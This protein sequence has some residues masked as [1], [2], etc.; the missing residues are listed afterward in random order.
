MSRR[1]FHPAGIFQP[2]SPERRLAAGFSQSARPQPATNR[3]SC[4]FACCALREISRLGL[5]RIFLSLLLAALVVAVEA[6][7]RVYRIMPLGD[8]I[9]EGGRTFSNYRYPLWEKLFAAGYLVEFVGSRT[10]ESRVGPL[11]HEGYGGRNAEFLAGVMAKTFRTNVADIVL[12]H[13]G[14]NHTNTEAPVPGMVSATE[15]MIRTARAANPRVVVL[16]AQVIPSGKLPKYEYIPELNT[17]LGE[18]ARRLNTP[19]SPV[20]AVNMAESFDW[21]MDAIADHV[22]PNASGAEKMAQ[23]WFMALTNVMERPPR[24]YHPR[25]MPYKQAGGAELRLHVFMP[26]NSNAKARPAIVFFFGGGWSRGTPIQFYPEC[27]HFADLGFVA[28]SADYRIASVNGTT[29]IESVTDGKSAIRWVRQHAGELGV[30]PDRIVAAGASAGGQAAAAAGI[31]PG[32][33]EKDEDPMV[34]SRP[35]ALVLWYPVIDNGPDGYG[36]EAVKARYQEFSPLHNIGT[37]APPTLFLLGTKD[38]LVPVATAELFKQRMEQGGGRCDMKLFP[39]AGHP[40]Y[41][42]RNA[43]SQ[44]RAEALKAAD[45]FLSSLGFLP[46]VAR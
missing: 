29:P 39:G 38:E 1:I 2:A 44:L 32:L 33:E 19:P 13:A 23:K 21:R 7:Q 16:V 27:A 28:M 10:S 4:P 20:M 8:S 22:H 24:T 5:Q 37:N 46:A 45:E 42:Y 41:N 35:N 34:S 30:D 17:A 14:H 15:S 11:H 40:V 31:V 12:I 6:E 9:T 36:P 26:T 3:L 25:L 43:A 18:L